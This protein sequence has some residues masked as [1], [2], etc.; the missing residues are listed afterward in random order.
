[1]SRDLKLS[2]AFRVARTALDVTEEAGTDNLLKTFLLAMATRDACDKLL[3][4]LAERI[5]RGER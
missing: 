3:N 5:A 1:M 2:D 4:Y